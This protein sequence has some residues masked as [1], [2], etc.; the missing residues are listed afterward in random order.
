MAVWYS[1][2]EKRFIRSL[3]CCIVCGSCAALS[4]VWQ[5]PIIGRLWFLKFR[6]SAIPAVE[7]TILSCC[8]GIFLVS[9]ASV[10]LIPLSK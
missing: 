3:F 4:G 6:N 10:K 7:I 2:R 8:S 5:Y 1:F 9:S